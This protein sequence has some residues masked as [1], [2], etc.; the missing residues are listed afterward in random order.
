[1]SKE[2]DAIVVGAGV[3]GLSAAAKLVEAGLQVL[4]LERNLHPGGTAYVYTRK[5]FTF[6]MGPLGFSS[7]ELVR[8]T[9]TSLAHGYDLDFH[10]VHY[11]IRAFDVKVSLSLSLGR[12]KNEMERLFPADAS[13]INRFFRDMEDILSAMRFPDIEVNRSLLER[14]ARTPARSYLSGFIKDWRLRRIAGSLG[15][16]EAY[17][18]LPLLAAMWNL[19]TREGIWY[20][21]GG[22]RSFC[23]K[24][25]KAATIGGEERGGFCEIRLGAEVKEIRVRNGRISGVTMAGGADIDAAAVI[26]N[27]DY[28]TTFMGLVKREALPDGWYRAVNRAK[29]TSSIFQVSLGVDRSKVDLSAFSEASRLISR[30]I[31]GSSGQSEEKLD[32]LAAEVD[33]GA[34]GGQELEVSLWSRED[35]MLAPEGGAVIVIRTE[36]DHAHFAKYRPAQGRRTPAY[37]GY[38]MRLAQALVREIN[39]LIPGLKRSVVVMDVA[40][41]LTF[42]D[43]GGRSE[44]AVAGWSWDYEHNTDYQPVELVRTPIHGLYMAGYQAY[45]A[46]LMGGVPMAMAS[47]QSAANALL[48]GA[49]PVEE[50]RIPGVRGRELPS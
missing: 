31:K 45:S 25:V 44:G 10:R 32:W 42:E 1:M 40:T 12:M 33:P 29:Q 30:R 21:K 22:M 20:P 3:G 14:A 7:P 26:S 9:L 2:W 24:L 41:P 39:S 38:K 47:G 27:A 43:Q 28:K 8:H 34:L 37:G 11:Q 17:T 46:P 49:G 50:I 4:V 35:P 15:T 48:Q 6:P 18:G 13:G 19:M 36:A 16:R 23:H 5:G